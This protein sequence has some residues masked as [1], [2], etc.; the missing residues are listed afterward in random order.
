M[1]IAFQ[2]QLLSLKMADDKPLGTEGVLLLSQLVWLQENRPNSEGWVEYSIAECE[3]DTGLTKFQQ[4]GIRTRLED[5]GHIIV[6]RGGERGSLWIRVCLEAVR[7]QETSHL[8]TARSQE[9]ELLT[10]R[11]QE[12]SHLDTA[13]SQETELL[14]VRSQETSHLEDSEVKKLHFQKSRNF[15]SIPSK[16]LIES[17]P[18]I[19]T[20]PQ[21]AGEPTPIPKK[22]PVPR[23]L[24]DTPNSEEEAVKFVQSLGGSLA[25]GEAFFT[26]FEAR[27]W[28]TKEGILRDWKA[29]ARGWVNRA[30]RW[31]AEKQAQNKASPA[32]NAPKTL[33][34]SREETEAQIRRVMEAGKWKQRG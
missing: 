8:N 26:H 33:E 14:T 24:A 21:G 20:P 11:S 23:T 32:R 22:D 9:T 2:T 30:K 16:K 27:G 31:E 10:V 5:S 28:R 1:I 12:T 3:G 7:S 15:T 18:P 13:R 25:D 34:E 29:A 6:K 19:Y 4:R 17:T